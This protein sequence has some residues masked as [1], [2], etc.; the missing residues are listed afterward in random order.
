MYISIP[1]LREP[2]AEAVGALSVRGVLYAKSSL[3]LIVNNRI[4]K[5]GI[6]PSAD[7]PLTSLSVLG[8]HAYT[9]RARARSREQMDREKISLSNVRAPGVSPG[10]HPRAWPTFFPFAFSPSAHSAYARKERYI[11]RTF[12]RPAAS[13]SYYYV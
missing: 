2:S 4:G 10:V 1:Q 7:V 8:A 13:G 6:R 5:V 9:T 3:K 11:I 12:S